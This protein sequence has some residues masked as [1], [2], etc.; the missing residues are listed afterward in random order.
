MINHTVSNKLGYD[1]FADCTMMKP[2]GSKATT[3]VSK[4]SSAYA[5]GKQEHL[6]NYGFYVR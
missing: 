1:M 6:A 5:S 2:I 3:Q 4:T